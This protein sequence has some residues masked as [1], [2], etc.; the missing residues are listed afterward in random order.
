MEEGPK[1]YFTPAEVKALIP[2]LTRVMGPL[3]DAH[4]EAR[5]IRSALQEEQDRIMVAGGGILDRE[6]WRKRTRRLEELTREIE[7][8]IAA[9]VNLGGMPKDL[10]MGLVDFPYRLDNE[11]VNLCWRLGETKIRFWHGLDEG[12]AGRKPL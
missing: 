7:Q 2:E 8:G 1:K 12:Y 3:M 4:S 5:T 11:E 6:S 9:I 10:G